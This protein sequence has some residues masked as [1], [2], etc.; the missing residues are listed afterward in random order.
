MTPLDRRT[1]LQAAG[2]VAPWRLVRVPPLPGNGPGRAV[3][4]RSS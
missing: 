4:P 1:F 3:A 2:G